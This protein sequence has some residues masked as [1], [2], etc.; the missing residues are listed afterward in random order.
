MNLI[1]REKIK[2][3]KQSNKKIYK[4][5]SIIFIITIVTLI[6]V[7]LI[8]PHDSS[9]DTNQFTREKKEMSKEDK[10]MIG[11]AIDINNLD[12]WF[13]IV[14]SEKDKL[15][16]LYPKGWAKK[17]IE[18]FLKE[19]KNKFYSEAWFSLK[20]RI[21]TTSCYWK[22]LDLPIEDIDV[23]SPHNPNVVILRARDGAIIFN[24]FQDKE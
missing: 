6:F 13:E 15:Y 11:R 1:K 7:S 3:E 10:E 14:H 12:D 16:H 21:A 22:L 17:T 18:N 2:N 8:S 20:N 5:V 4:I 23:H 24:D 19:P 9:T